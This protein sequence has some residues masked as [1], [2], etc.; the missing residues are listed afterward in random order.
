MKPII[1]VHAHVFNARDIPIKGYLQSRKSKP[2]L[3]GLLTPL[4]AP[5]IARCLRE[6]N[7]DA[8][9]VGCNLVTEVVCAMMGQEYRN[10]AETLAQDVRDI[11]AEMV[12][13]YRAIDL[14]VP[15]MVDFEYWFLNSPDNDIKSQIDLVA[16]HIVLPYEGRIHPFVPFCPAREIAFRK[17]LRNPDGQ[18]ERHSSLELVK[19]A[20]Q[21]KGFIGVKLYNAL[22]YRPWGNAEVDAKRTR[23]KIHKRK[24]YDQTITGTEYDAVLGEL[25]D[26]CVSNGVPITAHC[27]MDGIESYDDASYDFGKAVFWREV[28]DQPRYRTLRVNLAHFGWNKAVGYGAPQN[29]AK[30]IC[31]MAVAYDHLYTDVSHHSVLSYRGRRLFKGDY[32]RMRQDWGAHWPKVKS[33]ILFGIDWHVLKRVKGFEDFL[34]QYVEVLSHGELYNRDEIADFMGGN[35]MRFLGLL[36]GGQN[37]Q[38]LA[39][40]YR[41]QGQA[42]PAWFTATAP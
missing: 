1:D 22:G 3:E 40:F 32:A 8:R 23:I 12:D 36:P 41:N 9:G 26:Y 38:R 5:V 20:I 13:T 14:F 35:A 29:W 17:G 15:L 21:N 2:F 10:W 7:P 4:L 42:P 27:V 25:Y 19:D 30:D 11:T 34:G 18:V 39:R 16:E 24:K 37:R 31:R 33:K 6:E 28:L